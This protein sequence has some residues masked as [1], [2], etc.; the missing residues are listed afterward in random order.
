MFEKSPHETA[1]QRQSLDRWDQFLRNG[2]WGTCA[3][4]PVSGDRK[5]LPELCEN[6][7]RYDHN[8][9]A[10]E[11]FEQYKQF[12]EKAYSVWREE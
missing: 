1:I 7:K 12:V 11:L 8:L 6:T 2:R 3:S 4:C 5:Q 9:T 10:N